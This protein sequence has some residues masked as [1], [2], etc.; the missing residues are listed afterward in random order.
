M[1][2]SQQPTSSFALLHNYNHIQRCDL[3]DI[4]NTGIVLALHVSVGLLLKQIPMIESASLVSGDPSVE[5]LE[6]VDVCL[7]VLT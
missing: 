2:L 4:I 6:E 3:A 7:D 5:V 1:C